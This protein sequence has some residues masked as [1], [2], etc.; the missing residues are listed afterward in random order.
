M[1]SVRVHIRIAAPADLVWKVVSDAGQ[2]ADWFPALAR[3]SAEGNLRSVQLHNGPVISEEIVTNDQVL[4]RFQHAIRS[5]LPLDSHLATIDVLDDGPN[6]LVIYGADVTPP[7]AAS[8]MAGILA[9]A[10]DGLKR[11]VES[12]A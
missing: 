9:E 6:A 11:F 10:V 4:R 2:V 3:S 5:G 12:G 8:M 7:E 1:A